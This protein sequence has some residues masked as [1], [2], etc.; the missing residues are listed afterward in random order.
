M[1]SRS[2]LSSKASSP[3]PP[4]H[5]FWT[6]HKVY[7]IIATAGAALAFF[8]S[9]PLFLNW[10]QEFE[11]RSAPQS[12]PV[13]VNPTTK[14][15]TESPSVNAML[16]SS[17]TPFTAAVLNASDV[18]SW[19]YAAIASTPWYEALAATDTRYV[20]IAPG[21]RKEQIAAAFGRVLGWDKTQQNAFL[22]DTALRSEGT[23]SPGT[24]VIGGGS[25]PSTIEDTLSQRFNDIVLSHYATSTAKVVPLSE[26]L[27]IASMIQRETKDPNDM[28]IISGIIWNRLFAGMKLQI[29][30]TVQYAKANKLAA[31]GIMSN[32]WPAVRPA[33]LSIKSPYNTYVATS[34]PPAPISEP[35]VYAILAALNPV[36]TPCYF[37][38]H[39]A[40][41]VLHC[42]ATY[43]EH[44]ALLKKYYGQGK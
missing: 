40:N 43:A 16:S 42:S 21:A 22:A 3:R 28:R 32:W 33:D 9:I 6:H 38:F 8:L 10:T 14:T 17:A 25:T 27:T 41:H 1:T 4:R 24:Y 37:Y 20:V 23:I 18:I 35:S 19:L 31:A 7:G 44:V 11:I 26:A 36:Q 13:T 29:D 2:V 12:F 15:I 30:S 5:P 34:L 39:D